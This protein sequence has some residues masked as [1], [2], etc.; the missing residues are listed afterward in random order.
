MNHFNAILVGGP[1]H[2]GKSVLVY[3]LTQHL[4]RQGIEHYVVRACPDGE[5][6]WS[7]ET[8]PE[9][10]RLIRQKGRFTAEFVELIAADLGR[11]HLPL[12]VDAGGRPQEEQEVIFAQCTHAILI[13]VDEEGIRQW[14]A[15][16]A[17]NGLHVIAELISRLEGEPAIQS[18]GRCFRAEMS[19]LVRHERVAGPVFDALAGRVAT[20][21]FEPPE[22]LRQQH[23]DSAPTE[24]T[25]DLQELARDFSAERATQWV[26]QQLA[27][28]L[29]Y[30]PHGISASVYG[31]GPNWIFAALAVH[32]Q[33][34]KF[35]QFDVRLGWVKPPWLRC[36][37]AAESRHLIAK[38][39]RQPGYLLIELTAPDYYIDYAESDLVV[40]PQI[41]AEQGSSQGIILSGR[42][43]HWL[44]TGAVLAYTGQPWVAVYQ[45]QLQ[46]QAVVV[47]SRTGERPVGALVLCEY[48]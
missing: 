33:P 2:S 31:R 40:L 18:D 34:S 9:T 12:L 16:A 3:S 13:A 10:V 28:V 21:L 41:V 23:L 46:H 1:P 14:R 25:I 30:V 22:A 24:L 36:G 15:I 20:Y 17:R 42:I 48:T 26:P 19:G 11:R 32:A 43:P 44:L 45:P 39:S 29:R 5:G 35:Y 6:D 37:D 4:R 8:P 47:A 38:V 27:A 7:N